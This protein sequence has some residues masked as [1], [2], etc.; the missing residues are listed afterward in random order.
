MRLDVQVIDVQPAAALREYTQGRLWLG[1]R[2]FAPRILCA[3]V[4]L[5]ECS[6]GSAA[7]P[8]FVC[9]IDVWLRQIGHVTVR[10]V[11]SNPYVALDLAIARMRHKVSRRVRRDVRVSG[12]RRGRRACPGGRDDSGRRRGV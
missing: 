2:R 8:R 3:G 7:P 4:W 12:S 10:H 9:R 5:T 6:D 1:L 11:E